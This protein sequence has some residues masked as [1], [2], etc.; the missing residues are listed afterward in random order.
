[1]IRG[2]G[3][4]LCDTKR[5]RRLVDKDGRSFIEKVFSEVEQ[6]YCDRRADRAVC[7][8]ARFAAKEALFKATGRGMREGFKWTDVQVVN[9]QLG[10]PEIRLSGGTA[11]FVGDARIHLSLSHT[12]E[13]AIAYV[14]IE[15]VLS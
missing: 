3:V 15:E 13:Y 6:Q 11:D 1:M 10:R 9:D 7:Y 5:I 12:E 8:A 2:I 14:I 4:D